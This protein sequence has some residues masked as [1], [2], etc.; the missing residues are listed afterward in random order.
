METGLL[1]LHRTLGYVVFVVALVDLVLALTMA[2]S[3][4]R[5]ARLLSSVHTFGFLM[6]GRLNLLI[7]ILLLALLPQW[8]MTTW[9]AWAG[10]LLWGP[11]EAVSKRLVAPE[12]AV[13]RDGGT[14]SS[15]MI[16]GTAVELVVVV[17]IFGLMSARP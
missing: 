16:L 13:A 1:H 3:D 4:A 2:R 6:A 11:I 14:A 5:V 9:W 17:A 10:L 8:P 15:R 7:G 12:L